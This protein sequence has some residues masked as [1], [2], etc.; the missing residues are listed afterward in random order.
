M[1]NGASGLAVLAQK[2]NDILK[3]ELGALL[4]NLGKLSQAF[5]CYQRFEACQKGNHPINPADQIY[6]NFNFQAIA[7]LVAE[8]ITSPGTALTPQ[9]WARLESSA[10][11]WLEATT[12]ALLPNNTR[13][14]LQTRDI[15]LPPPLDDRKYAVG[16]FIEFQA[17]K[18]YE[19]KASGLRIEVIFP[20]GSKAT[21]LL[22]ISHDAASGIEKEGSV[23][24]LGVQFAP[25]TYRAT[26][27]GHETS[28]DEPKTESK[29][30]A[31]IEAVLRGQ[32]KEIWQT[33]SKQLRVG[34]GDTRRT[35]NDVT[36]WDLCSSVA[37]Y[38]KAAVARVVLDKR[39]VPRNDFE[40]RLLRI[41]FNGLA[42]LEQAPTI[43]DLLGRRAALRDALDQVKQLLEVTHPLGNEIYRDEN[44]SAFIVPALDGDDNRGTK[45]LGLVETLIREAFRQSR[46]EGELAPELTVSEPSR[47]AAKLNQ[48]L[49]RYLPPNTAFAD[50]MRCWWRG[51]PAEI[52]TTCG[53]RPQGWGAPSEY[54]QRKAQSRN[55]CYVCLERR[56]RR[57]QGWADEQGKDWKRTI[58]LD[59]VADRNGRL[60][61]LV[62]Q[63]DLKD[64]LNGKMVQTLLVKA[65]Q[66]DY[67]SKMPSF[68]RLRRVW[69]TTQ[70]FWERVRDEDIPAAVQANRYRLMIKP[71]NAANLDLGDYH[72]YEAEL[73]GLR[74]SLVW[75]SARQS[76]L[77]ADDLSEVA[78]KMGL[79]PRLARRDFAKDAD[80]VKRH[81]DGAEI[82]LYEPGG[83]GQ[84]RR[85]NSSLQVAYVQRSS[86]PYA[87]AI[88]LLTEPATFMA[89]VPADQALAVVSR[90]AERFSQEMG[91]VRN[92]LP[93]FVGAVFFDRR[94]PLLTALDAGR[95]LLKR[96]LPEE[97]WIV[98]GNPTVTNGDCKLSF[99]NG[100]EW[101]VRV[102]MGDGNTDD[103]WYPYYRVEPDANG[104]PPTGRALQFELPNLPSPPSVEHWVHVE[105]LEASDKVKLTPARFAY[106]HL[107]TSARRFEATETHLW[108]LEEVKKMRELW[109]NL[110]ALARQP[111][112]PLTDTKLR[113][114][115]ALFKAK[116]ELWRLDEEP[117]TG[118]DYQ[119]RKETFA[120]MVRATLKKE[121]LSGVLSS[122]QVLDGLFDAT[123]ELYVRII[124]ER[125]A[126]E[127][128]GVAQL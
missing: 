85:K 15:E 86:T 81:L 35:I 87:P 5:L 107:D 58:W 111:K 100:I 125:L 97:E 53:L 32:R 68:A 4:H 27:F 74:T 112:N 43:T 40:W 7:G 83:Y 78:I 76:L 69:E 96:E 94:Q 114:V 10:A 113:A 1:S 49:Q 62:G 2:R 127:T 99:N 54:Y 82:N 39:W 31:V 89:L 36:L 117:Q 84:Q 75:D 102:K 116:R 48:L 80:Y 11:D 77:T 41:A 8:F 6:E 3:A 44:G 121:G 115:E 104:N 98:G 124:K 51:A 73:A 61:L 118:A 120:E 110:K 95:R 65:A 9:D 119:R 46:L 56:G 105:H 29:R 103:I 67:V 13:Q 26:A 60:A 59:E 22:E 101:E 19:P 20:S 109:E 42:F 123:M 126:P 37:G 38:Y 90:I 18:W 34:V 52:C 106:L 66:P 122:E 128:A 23:K 63:F 55:V 70:Q 12:N 91:K 50:A 72:V 71:I 21:E 30:E 17:Y 45:L 47:E 28:I 57:A 92:R 64:W 33:A 14:L 93:F 79:S 16:D 108:R 25:P 24:G 88:P